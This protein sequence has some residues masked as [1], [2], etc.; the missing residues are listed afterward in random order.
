MSKFPKQELIAQKVIDVL[1]QETPPDS[2][3]EEGVATS[4]YVAGKIILGLICACKDKK[5]Y[6][7]ILAILALRD[8]ITSFYNNMLSS[9]DMQ[10]VEKLKKAYNSRK[11]QP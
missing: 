7:G 1:E 8:E 3:W 10:L 2:P 11:G 4:I 6:A 5:D 9:D